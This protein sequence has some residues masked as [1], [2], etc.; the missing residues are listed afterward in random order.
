MERAAERPR[1]ESAMTRM[2]TQ[3]WEGISDVA[4]LIG[5][6]GIYLNTREYG[7]NVLDGLKTTASNRPPSVLNIKHV[8]TPEDQHY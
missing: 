4:I 3:P 7:R 5:L 2:G 1:D 8:Q 6:F